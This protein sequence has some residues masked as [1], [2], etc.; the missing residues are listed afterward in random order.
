[1]NMKTALFAIS[2]SQDF[3]DRVGSKNQNKDTIM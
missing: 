2:V 1:M 3:K